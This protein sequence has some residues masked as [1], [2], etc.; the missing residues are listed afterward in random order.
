MKSKVITL[1]LGCLGAA[2]L[3]AGV[4]LADGQTLTGKCVKVVD[5][6]TLIIE[7]DKAKRTVELDGVDAP[8][9]QQPWG[10]Q[11]RSF[12][13]NVVGGREVE[14]EVLESTDDTVRARVTIDGQDL[15]EM[16]VASG[17]AWVP[18]AAANDELS[19]LSDKAR[20]MPCG[21]WRDADPVPPWEFREARS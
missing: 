2:L 16:L 17:L 3:L 6:D 19:E 8:E 1:I 4:V 21:L 5:G 18:D 11:V 20:E 15:S 14:I 13:R 12:V 10:K 7:C 9:L